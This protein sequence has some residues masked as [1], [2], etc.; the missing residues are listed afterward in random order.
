MSGAKYDLAFQRPDTPAYS[1]IAT[2]TPKVLPSISQRPPDMI[3]YTHHQVILI[4]LVPEETDLVISLNMPR[5]H[6][7]D[8][9]LT[10]P[11]NGDAEPGQEPLEGLEPLEGEEDVGEALK[12]ERTAVTAEMGHLMRRVL[13][14]LEIRDWSL[15]TP[16]L[17][18]DAHA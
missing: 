6:G 15:F 18:E 11:S 16:D 1:L 10:A 14:T 5:M 9:G 12:R 4:R 8:P 7:N 2:T 17:P 13:E 3:E